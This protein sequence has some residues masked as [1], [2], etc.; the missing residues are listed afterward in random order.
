MT[1]PGGKPGFREASQFAPD[2]SG[3]PKG[4]LDVDRDIALSPERS[5]P[6]APG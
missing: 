6:K 5:L 2:S 4:V 3:G 1:S